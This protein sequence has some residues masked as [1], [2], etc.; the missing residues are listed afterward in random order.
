MGLVC[1][2]NSKEAR[3]ARAELT[4]G[5]RVGEENKDVMLGHNL[6]GSTGLRRTLAFI[7]SEMGNTRGF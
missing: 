6:L 3:V 7:Q 4:K 5:T 1:L 2:G